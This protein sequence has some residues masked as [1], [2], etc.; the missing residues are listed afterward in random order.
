MP[1][2]YYTPFT[3]E[4]E[5]YIKD[6]YLDMTVKQLRCKLNCGWQRITRFLDKHG[7]AIPPE[8]VEQRRKMSQIKPGN[9]PFNK[10][11]KMSE[12]A[13]PEAIERSK[14]GWF[15][16]GHKPHNTK[17][18]GVISIRPDTDGREYKYI[19]ISEGHWELYHRVLWE[20]ERGAIPDDMI[21]AFK[22]NDSMNV[23]IDNLELISRTENMYR[24]SKHQ[25]PREIIPSLVLTKKLERKLKQL[26]DD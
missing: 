26:E 17:A 11:L 25:Y 21:V 13:S 9:V 5:Q 16:P 20:Q 8:L 10:G 24:N 2:G 12:Y 22:D 1:K 6:H 23:T 15:K 19:R 14:K 4:E 7:L 18:D 3:P